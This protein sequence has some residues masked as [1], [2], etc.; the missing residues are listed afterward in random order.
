LNSNIS[1]DQKTARFKGA[2]G[3]KRESQK[4][5]RE[6]QVLKYAS[7]GYNQVEIAEVLHISQAWVSR[8]LSALTKQA[9]EDIKYHIEETLPLE[10]RKALMLFETIKKRAI[11]ISNQENIGERD[12]IAALSLA[13]DAGKEIIT[14]QTEGRHIQSAIKVAGGLQDKLNSIEE[15]Q[16]EEQEE[17]RLYRQDHE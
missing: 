3:A 5:W 15:A 14:L 16:A 7:L 6:Q 2:V 11:D 17:L 8:I 10:R 4:V 1:D 13:K 9:Q 12:R